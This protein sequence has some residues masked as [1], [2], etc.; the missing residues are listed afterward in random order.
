[1]T[2]H[3][4]RRQAIHSWFVILI[5][6]IF[7]MIYLM[8][9]SPQKGCYSTRGMSGYGYLK[10]KKTNKVFVLDTLGAI[11]CTYTDDVVIK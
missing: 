11:V 9:C 5:G 3:S 2:P 6:I 7:A 4:Y 1:M 8:S 10:N